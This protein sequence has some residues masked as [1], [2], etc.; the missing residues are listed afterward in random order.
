MSVERVRDWISGADCVTVLTGAGVSTESG[1]PDYRGPDGV[2]TKDPDASKYTD[3][4]FYVTDPDVRRRAW[5]QRGKHPAWT[6][7]PNPAHHALV[8]LEQLGKLG[9][10]VTQNID[11]LHQTAGSS[12]DKVFEMHGNIFG[13]EC[14]GCDA[15]STMQAAL[16]R[17]AGGEPDP[18]CR[19]CG[20]ILKSAVVFFGESLDSDVLD[21]SVEAAAG[22]DVFIAVGTSLSVFPAAGL[23]D[24][25]LRSGARVVVCNAEPTM[26]DRHADA[27]IREQIGKALPAMVPQ[28]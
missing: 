23:V 26:Y 7:Q 12:P 18:A 9:A 13:V 24:V 19:D 2:W 3:I 28:Q 27:V 17:V 1:I 14:L 4:D 10:L 16:D 22:C 5:V 25:A 15:R 6:V 21:S 20:G 11:G 8:R